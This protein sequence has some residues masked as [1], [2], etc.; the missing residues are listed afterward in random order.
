[1]EPSLSYYT[2]QAGANT[3]ASEKIAR[4]LEEYIDDTDTVLNTCAGET[5]LPAA[6][7]IRNDI[8][9][10]APAD[11]H[12][13]CREISEKIDQCV[14]VVLHDPPFSEHQAIH[15]YGLEAEQWPGYA[16]VHREVHPLLRE[17]GY[18]IQAGFSAVPIAQKIRDDYERRAIVVANQL[19]RQ[20]DWIL[21]VDKKTTESD[22]ERPWST[23][24]SVI[25]NGGIATDGD[26]DIKY[27]AVPGAVSADDIWSAA[28]DRCSGRTLLLDWQGSIDPSEIGV[29][30]T[31]EP[32]HSAAQ[33]DQYVSLE[34][35]GSPV[36]PRKLGDS[37][38]GRQ[39]D[40]VVVW[41]HSTASNVTTEYDGHEIG[42]IRAIK[43]ELDRHF[44]SGVTVLLIG[45]TA[46]GMRRQWDYTHTGVTVVD[47]E[48][49]DTAWYISQFQK[50]QN[51]L[52]ELAESMRL[53][54]TGWT[55]ATF[56]S[57]VD[58]RHCSAPQEGRWVIDSPRITL[59]RHPAFYYHCPI[60]GANSG[61]RCVDDGS[62]EW[63]SLKCG[64]I[65]T[66]RCEY[67]KDRITQSERVHVYDGG[68][69]LGIA[70]YE[71]MDDISTLSEMTLP[72]TDATPQREPN[73]GTQTTLK[74]VFG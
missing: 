35:D 11:H 46:T 26:F 4:I 74:D 1:M 9:E 7:E 50:G 56:D 57:P 66:R 17:G 62:S 53:T 3:F 12:V 73:R 42:F 30:E 54:P 5:A 2:V 49:P 25:P 43:Q 67:A 22:S 60:C 72:D 41:P 18:I 38:P 8:D 19:G 28:R 33:L 34:N 71:A 29:A 47:G 10:P 20:D 39:P 32:Y 14:D 52:G 59:E 69:Y 36:P 21:T 31:I 65:H 23:T 48:N 44:G 63:T 68:N 64:N 13:D 16:P 51:G 58:N 45:N 70:E 37:L 61:A 6:T 15:T 55:T 27:R 40:A 24:A